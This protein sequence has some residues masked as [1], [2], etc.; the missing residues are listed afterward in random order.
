MIKV[1]TT[2]PG[3]PGKF[4]GDH[5]TLVSEKCVDITYNPKIGK[6][7][8]HTAA[9]AV[10]LKLLRQRKMSDVVVVDSGPVGKWFSWMQS[11]LILNKR[12]TLMVDC[13]WYRHDNRIVQWV[14]ASLK[15]LAARSVTLF[16]VWA[17]H[18]VRDYSREFGIGSEKFAY[19][20]FHTT[21]D[22]YA[23]EIAD[24]GFV[25]AGGNGD[26]DYRVLIEAVRG[27][28]IP[29]FIAATDTRLFEGISIPPNV[30]VK[31]LSHA[32]FRRKMASCRIAVVPMRGGLL[33]SGGQQTFLNS[34]YM[35]KP[36]IIIGPK[37]A[38]G[39]VEDGRN[40][41]VVDYGDAAGL[42]SAITLLNR[43]AGLRERMGA[44]ARAFA[45]Q[46]TTERFVRS[47]YSLAERIAIKGK[48]E[49]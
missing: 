12:P 13:L 35:G 44:S 48:D 27:L 45:S 32:D 24:E 14:K 25:F 15:R 19:V 29:V 39:Y 7:F 33:H 10:A 49:G 42:R 3:S 5:T 22:G 16:A 6:V 37:V 46:L 30:T 38:D 47:I 40:G 17:R 21:L 26:R 1:L 43:D 36:T 18:E 2:I 9:F 34:M 23:F 20:P 4:W 31:G 11:L 8:L 41:M 28:D